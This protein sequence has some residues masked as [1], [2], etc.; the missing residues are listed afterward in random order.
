MS[1][2]VPDG[3]TNPQQHVPAWKR[4]GLKLKY[5]KDTA[6]GPDTH[7]FTPDTKAAPT[8]DYSKGQPTT[9]DARPSKKRKVSTQPVLSSVESA[10]TS[11]AKSL[12]DSIGRVTTTKLPSEEPDE[13]SRQSNL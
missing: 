10:K 4:I 9:E 2:A 6:G 8:S 1:L 3:T 7:A 13:F 11:R 5:A 12:S